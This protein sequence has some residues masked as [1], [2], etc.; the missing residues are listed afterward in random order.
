M[1]RLFAAW[2]TIGLALGVAGCLEQPGVPCGS[3]TCAPETV[4]D[5]EVGRCVAPGVLSACA[6]LPDMSA[7][8]Y[9]G[10]AD[11]ICFDQHCLQRGCGNG[12]IEPGEACDDGNVFFDDGCSADCTSTEACGNGIIDTVQGEQ[13][14]DGNLVSGDGC[15][16]DCQAA[17]CGDGIVD[18]SLDE[19]CDC[20]TDPSAL[21]PGCATANADLPDAACRTTCVMPRCGDGVVDVTAGEGCDDGNVL[22]GDGC[23]GLCQREVCGNGIVDVVLVDDGLT[24][25]D[26]CDDGNTLELDGCDSRCRIHPGTWEEPVLSLVDGSATAYDVA[27]RR[28]VS[29]GSESDEGATFRINAPSTD[30]EFASGV[31]VTYDVGRA[32]TVL[33][34]GRFDTG[35]YSDETWE[36]DGVEWTRAQP[37]TV[38]P[39]ARKARLVYDAGHGVVMLFGGT[40]GALL[41]DTWTWDGTT[42][43]DVS[44][45]SGGPSPRHGHALAY[46]PVHGHYDAPEPVVTAGRICVDT[47][48]YYTGRLTAVRLDDDTG[49]ITAER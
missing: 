15:Q 49:L 47:G 23:S 38:S 28:I 16:Y 30:T 32:R 34:G 25:L 44:P 36:W 37:T 5:R 46:D 48:A 13:C 10:L 19:H 12:H 11:G 2:T 4:C 8:Q 24:T 18:A 27:R 14:D 21:P 42:W 40:A 6:H 3:L 29:V 39:S 43:R 41:G 45:A 33:F 26:E 20:G 31:G 7:C 22:S 17:R 1:S 9:P 35:A